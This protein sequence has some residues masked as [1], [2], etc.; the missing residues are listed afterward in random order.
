MSGFHKEIDV[1]V[2]TKKEAEAMGPLHN[3]FTLTIV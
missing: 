1:K 2:R 3:D